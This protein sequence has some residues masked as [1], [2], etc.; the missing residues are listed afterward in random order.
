[1]PPMVTMREAFESGRTTAFAPLLTVATQ[2]DN[3]K[4]GTKAPKRIGFPSREAL[5]RATP[6]YPVT[7][8][9]AM[10]IDPWGPLRRAQFPA[11]CFRP[12]SGENVLC[13]IGCVSA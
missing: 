7:G 6:V 1:M 2:T 12:A 10:S 4:N 5:R 9:N 13:A 8:R 3:D 11:G